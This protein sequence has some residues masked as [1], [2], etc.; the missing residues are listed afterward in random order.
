MYVWASAKHLRAFRDYFFVLFSYRFSPASFP[1]RT[2]MTKLANFGTAA[3]PV[4]DE[5]PACLFTENTCLFSENTCFFTDHMTC[6]FFR[7]CIQYVFSEN[8]CLST[9]NTCFFTD[10]K[11]RLETQFHLRICAGPTREMILEFATA[12]QM[13]KRTFAIQ[14]RKWL[15]YDLRVQIIWKS[16]QKLIQVSSMLAHR[17]FNL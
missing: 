6:S 15:Q 9:G 8:T 16:T 12:L 1:E 13:P 17:G 14:I 2:C 3:G 4:R 11:T 5:S 10:C 7:T